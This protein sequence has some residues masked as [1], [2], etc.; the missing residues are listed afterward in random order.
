[1]LIHTNHQYWRRWSEILFHHD[2][3]EGLFFR[4]EDY[5]MIKR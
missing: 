4:K 2:E 3:L 1:M 5:V